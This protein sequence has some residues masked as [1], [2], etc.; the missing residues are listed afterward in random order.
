MADILLIHGSGH[1]AWC[2]RDTIPALT[3]FGH[4]VEAIDLPSHGDDKTPVNEVT[5]DLYADRLIAALD[6]PRVLVGHSMGGAVA[7]VYAATFPE[8]IACLV[9]LDAFGPDFERAEKISAR[10]RK[11]VLDRYDV[12]VKRNNNNGTI[13]VKQY[14]NLDAAV[15]ARMRT[16]SLAPGGHQW[17]SEDAATKMV[18]RATTTVFT[19]SGNKIEFIHDQRLKHSEIILYS[20]AQLEGFWKSLQCPMYCLVAKDGWPF[21][22]SILHKAH[23]H[24]RQKGLLTVDKLPGSHHFHAD[25]DTAM[26]V[27]KAVVEY[28]QMQ[29][30]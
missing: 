25:P 23:T 29:K 5:L 24:V 7:T 17:L 28:L 9:T 4:Q 26:A 21:P 6:R 13:P 12:N 14:D 18:Q 8:Q 1:G 2:W 27:A 3:A 22:G 11:H 15:Q 19:E 16:A 10:M 30:V 20:P